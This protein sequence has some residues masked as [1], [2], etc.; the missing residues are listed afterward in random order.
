VKEA[1][2]LSISRII[3]K[4]SI[5]AGKFNIHFRSEQRAKCKDAWGS[6]GLSA[7]LVYHIQSGANGI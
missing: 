1:S 5:K 2:T 3:Y 6:N 4:Q 7:Y